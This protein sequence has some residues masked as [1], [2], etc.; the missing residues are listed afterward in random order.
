M[1]LD[2]IQERVMRL[3]LSVSWDCP[4]VSMR[5]SLGW[6]TPRNRREMMRMIFLRR[7]LSGRCPT[8]LRNVLRTNEELGHNC[9][10]RRSKNLY[11]LT[12]KSS[13]LAKSFTYRVGQEW[14]KL[15]QNIR[16]ASD[17]TFKMKIKHFYMS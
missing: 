6:M 5:S 8:Y 16:D 10:A 4:S 3:I 11:L 12:P 15:P 7:Y 17:H 1:K 13:W 14:N 9:S 2:K